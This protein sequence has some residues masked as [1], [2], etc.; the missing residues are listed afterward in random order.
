MPFRQETTSSCDSQCIKSILSS[1]DIAKR[2]QISKQ[3]KIGLVSAGTVTIALLVLILIYWRRRIYRTRQL[4]PPKAGRSHGA[5]HWS[6]PTNAAELGS[7]QLYEL[8]SNRYANLHDIWAPTIIE[9]EILE[10][11]G[12]LRAERRIENGNADDT[13]PGT[14]SVSPR[15]I[16]EA[17]RTDM[18]NSCEVAGCRL[19]FES[20]G[21]YR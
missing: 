4:S 20:L 21:D 7:V 1:R 8:D 11:R 2:T 15:S 10:D 6:Y 9:R 17:P 16:G 12:N 18:V 3:A 5:D 13:V 14:D 19:R